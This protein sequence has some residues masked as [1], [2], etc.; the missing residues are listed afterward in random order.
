MSFE[1]MNQEDK[2]MFLKVWS[3][4]NNPSFY[5]EAHDS[6]HLIAEK[7]FEALGKLDDYGDLFIGI[8]EP[9]L[10]KSYFSKFWPDRS[11][12]KYMERIKH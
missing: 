5:C 1:R 7:L 8:D 12:K 9:C 4:N 6:D 3:K 10:C 11:I 2:I